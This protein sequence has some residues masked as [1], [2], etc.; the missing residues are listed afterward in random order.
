LSR[1]AR[2]LNERPRK[3]LEY[4]TPAE[5][6]TCVMHSPIE[7]NAQSERNRNP[8]NDSYRLIVEVRNSKN[9]VFVMVNTAFKADNPYARYVA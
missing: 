3:V 1:V 6:L 2:K 7:L 5:N 8:A 4:E 9:N